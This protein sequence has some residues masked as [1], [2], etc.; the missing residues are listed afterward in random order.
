MEDPSIS[1]SNIILSE[2]R[3]IKK[4]V[5]LSFCPTNDMIVD[6]MTKGLSKEQLLHCLELNKSLLAASEEC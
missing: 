5:K 1:Q 6:I 2:I 3:L 4:V